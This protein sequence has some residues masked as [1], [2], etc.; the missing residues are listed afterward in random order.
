MS[1]ENLAQYFGT[2]KDPRCSGKVQHRLLDILVTAVCAVVACA[3]SWDGIALYGRSKL[4]WLKTFLERVNGIPSHDTFWRV[5]MLID[6]GA[7][8]A[9]FTAWVG[10]LVDKFEREVVAVDGKTV[11]RSFD[12]GREQSALYVVSALV[13]FAGITPWYRFAMACEQDLVLGQS[14][15]L[16]ET[17]ARFAADFAFR[18]R[19]ADGKSNEITAVPER[20]DQLALGN[21]IVT[22]DAMGCQTTP[23]FLSWT[24]ILPP[25][26]HTTVVACISV[27]LRCSMAAQ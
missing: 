15:K 16:A 1:I 5:F 19:C 21:S 25:P 4:A 10:S 23:W 24:R 11:R 3:V 26:S 27:G 6:P 8:E 17:V 12:H 14:R 9:G 7:F 22:L 20:L 18:R 13:S 2:I